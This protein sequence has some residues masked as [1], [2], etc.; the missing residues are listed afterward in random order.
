MCKWPVLSCPP[1]EA[2]HFQQQSVQLS[3]QYRGWFLNLEWLFRYRRN[4]LYKC[5]SSVCPSALAACRTHRGEVSWVSRCL[6]VPSATVY[7]SA[8]LTISA[9]HSTTIGTRT[10]AAVCGCR[11]TPAQPHTPGQ[12]TSMFKLQPSMATR[13]SSFL[14][15]YT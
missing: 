8:P 1:A 2:W 10:G 9:D 7:S 13:L 3:H 5:R 15:C 12:R 11:T 14:L 4:R 6:S